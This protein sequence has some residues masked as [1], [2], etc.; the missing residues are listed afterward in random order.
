MLTKGTNRTVLVVDDSKVVRE[1]LVHLLHELPGPLETLEAVTARDAISL[2]RARAPNVM[3]LDLELESGSGFEV[4]EAMRAEDLTTTAVVVL[5]NHAWHQIRKA[6][7]CAGARYFFDKSLEFE[8]AVAA[9]G[10][11]AREGQNS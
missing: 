7:L 11:L 10:E 3:L 8:Q 1:R 5:T 2:L 9:V 4:L 6:C